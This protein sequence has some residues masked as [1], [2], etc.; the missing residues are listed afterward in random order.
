MPSSLILYHGG[1]AEDGKRFWPFTHFGPKAAALHRSNTNFEHEPNGA[2]V[3]HTLYRELC[4]IL[5]DAA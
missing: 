2:Q 4:G 3:K 5:G 1:L